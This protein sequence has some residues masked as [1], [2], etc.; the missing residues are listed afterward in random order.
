MSKET[1]LPI[2]K[3]GNYPY[4]IYTIRHSKKLA[5]DLKRGGKGI[6]TEKKPWTTAQDFLRRAQELDQKLPIIFA[7][8][9]T[10]E[11]LIYFAYIDELDVSL[12]DEKDRRTTTIH[13][14]ALQRFRKMYT[15]DCLIVK[16]TRECLPNSFIKNL[17][18]CHTPDFLPAP[19]EAK[20]KRAAKTVAR[21]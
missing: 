6:F 3:S 14:S 4:T 18:Y 8:A 5:A 16:S 15:L 17:A 19:K 20:R 9:E 11:G 7:D 2:A 12:P 10:V 21:R 13:F 1:I